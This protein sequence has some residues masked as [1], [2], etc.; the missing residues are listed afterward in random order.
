M[1]CV[2]CRQ[3]RSSES[4]APGNPGTDNARTPHVTS[5]ATSTPI[6]IRSSNHSSSMVALARI[7][8]KSSRILADAYPP[9]S[10]LPPRARPGRGVR[11]GQAGGGG[12]PDLHA[13]GHPDRSGYGR[14]WT[15]KRA[16]KRKARRLTNNSHRGSNTI[17]TGYSV[18]TLPT[19]NTKEPRGPNRYAVIRPNPTP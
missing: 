1:P 18:G 2:S 19:P 7:L 5:G 3:A 4:S 10:T 8:P 14:P 13:R 17:T 9:S 12:D 16:A 6:A 11:T 15:P